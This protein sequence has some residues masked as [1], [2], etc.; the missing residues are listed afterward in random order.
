MFT[1]GDG[2]DLTILLVYVDDIIITRNNVATIDKL[3]S[4][5]KKKIKIKY[6]GKLRYFLALR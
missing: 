3:R 6:I 5:M 4:I 1:R 2:E